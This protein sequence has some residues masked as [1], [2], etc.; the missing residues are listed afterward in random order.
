MLGQNS[1]LQRISWFDNLSAD[2]G[3]MSSKAH[4]SDQS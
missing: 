3:K 2:R 1:L 4:N